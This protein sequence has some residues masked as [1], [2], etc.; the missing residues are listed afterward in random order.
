M[1][2]HVSVDNICAL[3]QASIEGGIEPRVSNQ[4]CATAFANAPNTILIECILGQAM[5]KPEVVDELVRTA[6]K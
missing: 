3:Y 5:I 4:K 1:R 6:F 2:L